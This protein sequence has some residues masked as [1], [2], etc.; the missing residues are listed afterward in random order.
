MPSTSTNVTIF[1][2]FFGI[3][4]LDAFATQN[5]WRVSFWVVI[6]L[7][8]LGASFI[9]RRSATRDEVRG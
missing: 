6:G 5:W 4:F 3:S 2:L 9:G 7:V 8:F 1:L